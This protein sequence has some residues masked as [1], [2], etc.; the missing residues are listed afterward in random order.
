MTLP[1]IFKTLRFKNFMGRICLRKK[2]LRFAINWIFAFV[3]RYKK[4][5][6]LRTFNWRLK[7]T[8]WSSHIPDQITHIP[9]TTHMDKKSFTSIW[10]LTLSRERIQGLNSKS[11]S[12]FTDKTQLPRPCSWFLQ[13]PP[14]S[15]IHYTQSGRRP[16]EMDHQRIIDFIQKV[17]Q[18]CF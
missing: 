14:T 18:L 11:K 9:N 4:M 1:R 5:R 13:E 16:F 7:R 10:N 12:Q 17:F 2:P 3:L 15:Q 6:L 8:R